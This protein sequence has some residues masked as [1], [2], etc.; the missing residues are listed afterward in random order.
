VV[1]LLRFHF[2]YRVFNSVFLCYLIIDRSSTRSRL[3]LLVECANFRVH[4]GDRGV[5]AFSSA[6]GEDYD[7]RRVLI[8]LS[9]RVWTQVVASFSRAAAS[10]SQ[11]ISI[12]WSSICFCIVESICRN[13]SCLGGGS[14]L[15]A[16]IPR[17]NAEFE[18]E[19]LASDMRTSDRLGQRSVG[20]GVSIVFPFSFKAAKA[21]T[22]A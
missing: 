8:C 22:V 9:N 2:R 21:A 10:Q 6:I 18:W 11:I 14:G 3:E 15:A 20:S 1:D 5:C 17:G 16:C 12:C 19:S 13:C 4:G 7:F